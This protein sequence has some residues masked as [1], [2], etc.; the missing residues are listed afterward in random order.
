MYI[1]ISIIFV[2]FFTACKKYNLSPKIAFTPPKYVEELP[3]KEEE[4]SSQLGSLFGT[5][6][7]P[8]FMDK[9]AMKQND[10]ITILISENI[11]SSS[12]ADKK[13]TQ[14]NNTN[15]GGGN[16]GY[17]GNATPNPM[18][19]KANDLANYNYNSQSTT[20][21]TGQGKNTRS[22]NFKTIITARIV[23]VLN[24]GNYFISGRKELLIN[25]EKQI[26]QITAVANP[27]NITSKNEINSK[28]L[29]D[30]RIMYKTQGDIKQSTSQGWITR[31]AEAFW[32]F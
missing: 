28:Y 4:I 23:K 14:N 7:N 3:Q 32:P 15:L 30:L 6:K 8:L 21:Y 1:K 9:R 12:T 16:V 18:Q 25:G 17:T 11:N 27:Y 29:A 26:V 24:N 5:G 22:E 19:K 20:S 2:I 10:I 13:L 31:A